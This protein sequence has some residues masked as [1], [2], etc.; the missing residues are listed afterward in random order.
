LPEHE[1]LESQ[2]S[3]IKPDLE[4][5]PPTSI[6][7]LESA[8]SSHTQ[9]PHVVPTHPMVTSSQYRVTN[10]NPK[11]VLIT[12]SSSDIPHNP[13]NIHSA[14]THP[15]WKVA[16]CEELKALHKNKT[17]ELVPCTRDLHVITLNG[18]LNQNSN[19]MGL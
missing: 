9:L 10:P 4:L 14:L 11:Y 15:E 19:L 2:H 18:F 13:Y 5:G 8:S 6:Q 7:P 17:W 12:M 1:N 16:M 3:P